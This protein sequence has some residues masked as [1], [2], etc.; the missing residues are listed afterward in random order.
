MSVSLQQIKYFVA[1]YEEGSV[2][3]AAEREDSS[4]PGLST[5]IRNMEKTLGGQL[6]ERSV[7]GVTPTLAGQ[8][9]YDHAVGILRSVRT[10]EQE[11]AEMG[12]EV[13]GSIR[14]GL[15]PSVARGFL[16]SML[17]KFVV[18]YPNVELNVFEAYSSTLTSSVRNN[19][20][21]FGITIDPPKLKGMAISRLSV[22]HLV[23]LTGNRLGLKHGKPLQLSKVDPLKIV[24]PSSQ[25]SLRAVIDRYI[26]INDVR[27]KRVLEMDAM[28]GT[29][30]F[31]QNSDWATLLPFAAIKC[32]LESQNSDLC[33]SPIVDPDIRA[34][35]YLIHQR[36]RPLSEAG[37]V[38][39]Q[40]M[41]K[42]AQDLNST[43]N[44]FLNKH[45]GT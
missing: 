3:R 30:E 28:Q 35:F 17:P 16:P 18:E 36:Q 43:W 19:E 2:S 29:V 14:V 38:F 27:V 10:A 31:V 20:V 42:E 26:R 6:F 22:E 25:T 24:L 33:V 34:D 32:D 12:R 4:Q 44:K 23:L 11:M 15:I 41:E 39:I 21:D 40:G 9:F 45:N 7:H 37:R 5:Q 8:Q 1:V 13:S